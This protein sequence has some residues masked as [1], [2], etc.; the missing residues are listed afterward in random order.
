[1][2]PSPPL[3]L[4]FA[5]SDP[6][7]GAGIQADLMTLA[8][9]GCHP[10]AA[11][12][13]LT[14]QD[15]R[16]IDDIMPIDPDWVADQARIVL[17]D[18]QIDAF[19]LGMLGSV[20]TIAAIAEVLSD[21]PEIPVVFDPVLASGRGDELASD[22]MI[23]AMQDMLLPQTTVLT[24][25]SMEA[26]RLAWLHEDDDDLALDVCAQ[27]LLELGCE[28]VL[29]TGTHENTPRVTNTLHGGEG[30]LRIDHWDRLPGSYHGSGCTLAS[31]LAASLAFGHDISRAA[32]EAQE[33]TYESL[34]AA[35]RPGMGQCIP[36]RLFWVRDPLSE[37][38]TLAQGLSRV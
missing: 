17:E 26:R 2:N 22:N 19:K 8:S 5:A 29:I 31:A 10:L 9:R 15:T 30:V 32:W 25:N 20:E 21:Y 18:M 37:C 38:S 6:T 35:F 3:V 4:A 23:A 13:A 24:P 36:E 12:T 27:R 34:K 11:I 14:I 33:F 28:Y 16:G 7:S 1:M